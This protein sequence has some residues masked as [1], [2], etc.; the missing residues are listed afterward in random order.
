MVSVGLEWISDPMEPGEEGQC[1]PQRVRG[2]PF[3][4]PDHL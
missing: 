2:V 3:A 1:I 4:W